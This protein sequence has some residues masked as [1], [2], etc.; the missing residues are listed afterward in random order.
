[1]ATSQIIWSNDWRWLLS[2]ELF[3]EVPMLDWST[4]VRFWSYGL[5]SWVFAAK[6]TGSRGGEVWIALLQMYTSHLGG[7]IKCSRLHSDRKEIAGTSC[8]TCF[9][10]HAH[11]F[12]RKL[13][14][15]LCKGHEAV[16]FDQEPRISTWLAGNWS[17]LAVCRRW[18]SGNSQCYECF[19]RNIWT[20]EWLDGISGGY[21]DWGF[22][23]EWRI[24]HR[25]ELP[26]VAETVDQCCEWGPGFS[27]GSS[28]CFQNT[29]P[30]R[31]QACSE[32][33]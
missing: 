27:R 31:T 13:Y 32:R 16:Y 14:N 28:Q 1:M 19:C 12:Q 22:G 7:Q 30:I 17:C 10:E 23:F 4:Y 29:L 21:S 9:E 3:G 33:G 26:D 24:W 25:D 11:L 5:A 6:W 18:D 8:W 20:G 15:T 2:S